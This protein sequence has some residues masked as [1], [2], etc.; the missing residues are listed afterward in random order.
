M[1]WISS[2]FTLISFFYSSYAFIYYNS[3]LEFLIMH[4]YSIWKLTTLHKRLLIWWGW[5]RER[6][7]YERERFSF[8]NVKASQHLG[9]RYNIPFINSPRPNGFNKVEKIR[10]VKIR[11]GD[12]YLMS[13]IMGSLAGHDLLKQMVLIKYFKPHIDVVFWSHEQ[14]FFARAVV[15]RRSLF[16]TPWACKLN[17][18][19]NR[20]VTKYFL[21]ASKSLA[22]KCVL[23]CYLGGGGDRSA[24]GM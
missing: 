9:C 21:C 19:F 10:W 15:R 23:W 7:L 6:H 12:I 1:I 8:L 4:D 3:S 24:A 14:C 20:K 22:S 18:T 11:L 13:G 16:C 2:V 5:K 17:S